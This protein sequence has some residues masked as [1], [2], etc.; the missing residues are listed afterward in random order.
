MD[1]PHYFLQLLTMEAIPHDIQ[2]VVTVDP[3]PSR[4][5][6]AP[7]AGDAV[8]RRDAGGPRG[9]SA[10]DARVVVA[11]AMYTRV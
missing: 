2:A 10:D 4:P 1:S 8:S 3:M 5:S 7:L 9:P 6:P 11:S